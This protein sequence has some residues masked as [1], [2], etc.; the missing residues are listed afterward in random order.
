[1]KQRPPWLSRNGQCPTINR[2]FCHPGAEI[3]SAATGGRTLT[4]L[5]PCKHLTTSPP[6]GGLLE[7]S[8]SQQHLSKAPKLI[9]G[10]TLNIV[11]ETSELALLY[12][13]TFCSQH[14]ILKKKKKYL[15][16]CLRHPLVSV[17][18]QTS[19][20]HDVCVRGRRIIRA[21]PYPSTLQQCIQ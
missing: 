3:S 12:A 18:F 1:M 4:Y 6:G 16:Y 11:S 10:S 13:L 8:L 19:G 2:L 21:H 15:F 17:Q 20:H 5:L 7:A 14:F 9:A